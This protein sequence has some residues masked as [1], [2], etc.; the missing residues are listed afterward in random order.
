M[1]NKEREYAKHENYG[2]YENTKIREANN[3]NY[4]RSENT[5]NA[6]YYFVKSSI[7]V[8]VSSRVGAT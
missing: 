5:R 1:Y 2:N 8:S 3:A 4:E 7:W 6:N